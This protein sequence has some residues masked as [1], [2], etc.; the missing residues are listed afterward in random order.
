MVAS[1]SFPK[2]DCFVILDEIVRD[3]CISIIEGVL[4]EKRNYKPYQE[5]YDNIK[6]NLINHCTKYIDNNGDPRAIKPLDLLSFTQDK[7]E[8]ENRKKTLIGLYTPEVDSDLYNTLKKMR[9]NNGL[10]FCPCCGEDGAPGTLDH[11]LPKDLFPELSIF[12]ANLTP[13]CQPCQGKKSTEYISKSGIRKFLHPYF[14]VIDEC[15]FH[16]EIVPPFHAPSNFILNIVRGQPEMLRIIISHIQAIDFQDRFTIYCE[17][18]HMHLL[19]IIEK[20]RRE[21]DPE[22]A[23]SII[24]LFLMQEEEKAK[25]SWGAI[26]YSSVLNTPKLLGYLDNGEFEKCL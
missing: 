12:L 17:T 4:E 1:V 7:I 20:K 6:A 9:H 14:D 11:Y 16:V 8:A 26:Y 5:F 19:R 2:G 24:K 22:T 18:K 15:F 23:E 13:M 21:Q 25:N 3:Y 10:I